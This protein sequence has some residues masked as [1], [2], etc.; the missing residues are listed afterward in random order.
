MNRQEL[1]LVARI[2]ENLPVMSSEIMQGWIDNPKGLQKFLS[3]L[4]PEDSILTAPE[5]VTIM[6]A[7]Q[8]D[9]DTF[10]QTR[11][12]LFIWSDFRSRVVSKAKHIVDVGT[13]RVERRDLVRD[14]KDA[15]IE[16]ALANH[17]FDENIVYAVIAE[18]IS[19][20]PQGKSGTLLNNGYANLFY[21]SSCVVC[22][23]WFADDRWWS[24][25]TWGR[26]GRRWFAGLRV[27][28]SATAA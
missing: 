6:F 11:P 2:L 26:G 12:G 20:Q 22:V 4:C 28:S 14:A 18:L 17:L 16:S 25:Y 8:R 19:K 23:H 7:E 27:F 15:D 24:V 10:F 1:K 21:V 13:Y 9:P 5:L 3:G